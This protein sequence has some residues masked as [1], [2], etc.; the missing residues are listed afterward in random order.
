LSVTAST[1]SALT[2][3]KYRAQQLSI[4]ADGSLTFEPQ[5]DFF[6]TYQLEYT[7]TDKDGQTASARV[8]VHVRPTAASLGVVRDGVGGFVIEGAAGDA[9]GAVAS[10]A[11][12]VNND[13]FADILLGAPSA[14][15]AYVVYGRAKSAKV[16]LAPLPTTS[17]ER[18]FFSVNGATGDG[19][20]NALASLGDLNGDDYADFAVAASNVGAAV[21]T[22]GAVYVLYGGK[23]SG[24]IA[25]SGLAASK[26][27]VLTGSTSAPI[28]QRI[29]NAGDFDG[30]GL[31]DLLVSG[32]T[33][34]GL[35]YGVPGTAARFSS[36]ID[37]VA[38]LM[39]IKGGRPQEGLPVGMDSAGDVDGDGKSDVVLVSNT[40]IVL[41]KGGVP[42]PVDNDASVSASG[43]LRLDLAN[44]ADPGMPATAAVAG[45]GN[46]DADEEGRDDLVIC[47]TTKTDG[48]HC[49]VVLDLAGTLETGW[50]IKGFGSLPVLAHGADLNSDGFSDLLFA[51]GANVFAVFGKR[52]GH[53]ELDLG[54]LGD[55][56]L[57][58]SAEAGGKVDSVATV[59]DV[60][61][62]GI[63][64]YAIGDS[65]ANRVYVVLGGKY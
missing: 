37:S 43:G 52:T 54:Q 8:N 38:G 59:G 22:T 27:I 44:P 48:L 31:A 65:S 51:D 61:G 7:V 24:G 30:D 33:V 14:S 20:G 15:R 11:G 2:P 58:F 47:E 29:A 5:A 49:R 35:V 36:L 13:G 60:N 28:A 19:A 18:A 32:T 17:S 40:S 6:G 12:D 16:S 57:R 26:G 3:A 42:F 63:T 62:D 23:L 21:S 1:D 55:A 45:G 10:A 39:Q 25:L 4:A 56:G 64:D 34:N 46:V 9:L 50:K 41:L 53:A